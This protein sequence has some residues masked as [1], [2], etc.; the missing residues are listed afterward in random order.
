MDECVGVGFQPL[1]T[2]QGLPAST[3]INTFTIFPRVLHPLEPDVPRVAGEALHDGMFAIGVLGAIHAAPRKQAGGMRD[4]DTKDL[5]GQDVINAL[6]QVR[7]F[8]RQ[9]LAETAG[10]LAQEYAR[11][12][13]RV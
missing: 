1:A 10:Y 11:L 4:R 5:L 6:L 2:V 7:N 3:A 9:P 12:R 13:A 8:N